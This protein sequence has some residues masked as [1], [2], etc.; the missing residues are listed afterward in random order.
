MLLSFNLMTNNTNVIS[1]ETDNQIVEVVEEPIIESGE[2]IIEE[3]QEV[4]E[5]TNFIKPIRAG[6]VTSRFGTRWGRLHG[7][8]DIADKTGTE[9]YA[10][11]AGEVV[12]AGWSGNYGNLVRI[13][14]V[15]GY[16]TYYAHCSSILVSVGDQVAQNQ[17]I[18]RMGM[19]GN[20]TG[21]HVHFEIRE[22]GRVINPYDYIY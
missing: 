7:G 9:I 12:Y 20:A 16:E 10:A 14:H 13:K 5:E 2:T 11:K 21:P 6:V 15:D 22:N 4:E 3:E 19:T 1:A 8:I 18:A 17:L